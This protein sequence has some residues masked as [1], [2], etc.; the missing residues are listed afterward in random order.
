MRGFIPTPSV[1]SLNV[2]P[3]TI[4]FYAVC[5]LIGILVAIFIG[6]SRLPDNA[7]LINEMAV[8]V[9]PAGVIGA[10]IYHVITT[11]EK[12]FNS[13]F[14]DAFKIWEGGL[15]IWGAIAGGASVGFIYL[16]RKGMQSEFLVIAD[17]LAPGIIF[18]QAIGR[19]GNWFNGELF[20]KPSTLPWA[21]EIPLENRPI[22]FSSFETFH[23]TFLYE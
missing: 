18:A 20:G 22:A 12:Y 21:L 7:D 1:S 8:Y 4:H 11:P 19:F 6:R 5:I 23:P 13:H 3:L 9:I 10:R 16:R 15:G 2:G 14:A 17:A